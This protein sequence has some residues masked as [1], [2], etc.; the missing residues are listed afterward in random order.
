MRTILKCRMDTPIRDML[1]SLNFLMISA[2]YATYE[3]YVENMT[4]CERG[5]QKRKD[6]FC[7][8]LNRRDH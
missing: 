3:K 2:D 7:L 5:F 4:T 1:Q 8:G 6:G